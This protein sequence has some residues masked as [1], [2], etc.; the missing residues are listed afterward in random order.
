MVACVAMNLIEN[1]EMWNNCMDEAKNL[2]TATSGTNLLIAIFCE[3][4]VPNPQELFVTRFTS[5]P[6]LSGY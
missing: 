6:R 4:E 2:Y 3:N 1:D 5:K